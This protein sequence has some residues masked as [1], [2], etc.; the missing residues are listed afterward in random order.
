MQIVPV[1]F[2]LIPL[3]F[4]FSFYSSVSFIHFASALLFL[5]SIFSF[6]PYLF[7]IF[8]FRLS[9]SFVFSSLFSCVLPLIPLIF[10]LHVF[11][12]TFFF[13]TLPFSSY[14]LASLFSFFC[15]SLAT[16]F[17][18]FWVSLAFCFLSFLLRSILFLFSFFLL[19]L[20]SFKCNFHLLFLLFLK[21]CKD[22]SVKISCMLNISFNSQ[23]SLVFILRSDIIPDMHGLRNYKDTKL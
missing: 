1:S 16:C 19:R 5:L 9:F 6:S 11:W 3:F 2:L 20:C 14:F 18:L 8:L 21:D 13:S 7:S 17:F 12:S 10:L 22:W 23:S 15:F 4:I